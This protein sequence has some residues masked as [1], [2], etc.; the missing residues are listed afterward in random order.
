MVEN[1]KYF[2]GETKVLK[3][4]KSPKKT[5]I[6]GEPSR[7]AEGINEDSSEEETYDDVLMELDNY[8]TE[9]KDM[10]YE[11]M[12]HSGDSDSDTDEEEDIK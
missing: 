8:N 2:L 11:A 7:I 5:T 4:L 9:S 6:T 12:E 10:Q 3:Q 1:A